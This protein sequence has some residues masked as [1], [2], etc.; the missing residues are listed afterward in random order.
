MRLLSQFETKGNIELLSQKIIAVFSS[1][2]TPGEIYNPGRDLFLKLCELPLSIAGG[3]QAPF[4]KILL[5]EINPQ[6]P[7]NI[8]Y[9]SA[10]NLI[11]VKNTGF[12]ELEKNNKV[13][14]VSAQSRKDRASKQDINKRD[15]LMF[16]QVHSVLFFYIETNG[17][18]Q[19][20]FDQLI[21]NN[22][23]VY[24]LQHDLN[25]N[26]LNA[27]AVGLDSEN[28]NLLSPD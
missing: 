8:I 11:S 12:T 1:K 5:K 24:T 26:L 22:F 15:Q 17:R 14:Y 9:Y 3:W 13:L 27:G 10:K 19:K 23:S 28:I 18:L 25:M 6:M 16:S 21:R 2:N 7:A 4:E 20:Y